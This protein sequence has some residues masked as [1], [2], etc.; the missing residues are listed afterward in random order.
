MIPDAE[1]KSHYA[2]MHVPDSESESDSNADSN[3]AQP[4]AVSVKAEQDED[5]KILTTPA[6]RNL[7]RSY[8]INLHEVIGTGRDGRILKEDV[9]K[10]AAAK[11]G[12]HE[13]LSGF[14]EPDVEGILEPKAAGIEDKLEV[15]SS[16]K[17]SY[18]EDEIIPVRGL[19]RAMVKT[20]TAAAMVPHFHYMEEVNMDALVRLRTSLKNV[21]LERNIKLTYL[22]FLI[23]ALS[24]ALYKH[25]VVNSTVNED[26]SEIR[27]KAS[28]NVGVAIGKESGLAVPNIKD[29]Q[30]LS[31]FEIAEELSRLTQLAANNKLSPEDLSGG[32]ITVSNFG[33]I[34]GKFGSPVL[35]LP[36]VAIL[37]LGR[38]Q[39]LPRFDN[40][41][42]VYPASMM[43]VTWGADHRVI[44]GATV[45]NLCNEWKL[46]VE[47]PERM[48]VHLR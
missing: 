20:M 33:A 29:V 8:G 39:K 25:P 42:H 40:S 2:S 37:G 41:G 30:H 3:A 11:E 36:E 24:V 4:L 26:V 43:G 31:I 5:R 27:C 35:N 45:A 17:G 23:K 9:L 10:F 28:H 6:V 47:E 48:I 34:G 22:P 13:E 19:R 32:T 1:A 16:K 18:V 12:L 38:V 44:D 21:A 14:L 15:S 7:A 46:L